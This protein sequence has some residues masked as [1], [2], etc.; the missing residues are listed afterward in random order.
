MWPQK[1]YTSR[2][3]SFDNTLSPSFTS[4]SFIYELQV[5]RDGVEWRVVIRRL[6]YSF[7]SMASCTKDASGVS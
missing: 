2:K 3:L 7:F 1:G 4:Y 5:K 6:I